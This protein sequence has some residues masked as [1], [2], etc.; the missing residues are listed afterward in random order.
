MEEFI[1]N[2]AQNIVS[3]NVF[4]S[5]LFFFISQSLQIL[6]PPYPGD[7]VLILEGYLSELANLNIF[8]IIFNAVLA[9]T[10][11]SIL[12]FIIGEKEEE[13]I[14][15]SRI[16]KYLFDTKK[17]EK[18]RHLF[19]RFGTLVIIISKIIPGI[20]SV[21]VLSAGIFKVKRSN[22]YFAIALVTLFHHSSLII[23]G[24]LLGENWTIIFHSLNVYNK[25]IIIFAVIGLI[26]YGLMYLLKRKLLR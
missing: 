19:D 2:F 5:Y 4:L 20:F 16:I 1:V 7:M 26:L 21:T 8:L 17:V 6:F 25:Y 13:K 23:L 9:T 10:L 24:K 22:A 15:K 14:L 18:L 3:E 11:S 12:L